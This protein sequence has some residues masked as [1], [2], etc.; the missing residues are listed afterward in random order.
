[1]SECLFKLLS[2]T[3]YYVTLKEGI[4]MNKELDRTGNKLVQVYSSYTHLPRQNG[5]GTITLYASLKYIRRNRRTVT[6]ILNVGARRRERSTSC[7]VRFVSD[8]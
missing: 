4:A 7:S 3:Q 2:L 8:K 6:S 1:V 5:E